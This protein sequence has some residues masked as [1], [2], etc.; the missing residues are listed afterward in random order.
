MNIVT[1][2]NVSKA[3][4]RSG[5]QKL[6]RDY[7]RDLVRT[8]TGDDAFYALK[9]LSFT[10]AAQESVAIIG[11]NGAGKS[12]LLGLIAGLV[13][14]DAGALQVSGRI[15]AL[16]ELGS[17]FHPELTGTEN[18]FLNAALLGF[19]EKQTRELFG[20]IVDFAELRD[21]ITSPLRTYS[22]GMIMRLAFSV[23]VHVD[24]AILIVD[25]V[26]A[27]GDVAFQDKCQRKIQALRQEGRSLICVTHAP[28]VMMTCDRSIWLHRGEL[29]MDGPSSE[30]V[31]A[32]VNY[33]DAPE[34]GLPS[35]TVKPMPNVRLLRTGSRG[36]G[37]RD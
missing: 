18:V 28:G 16:L 24:P 14:P 21:S 9:N 1:A 7:I 36:K 4:R 13:K 33:M 3:F 32:Y 37:R 12:T 27:V 35:A 19:N 11:A 22:T 15:A 6:M 2:T 34:F 30:V 10:I 23:A 25:E 29:V 17:G 8:K 31:P 20:S 5:G 26:M